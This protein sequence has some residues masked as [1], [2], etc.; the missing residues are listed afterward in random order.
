MSVVSDVSPYL[1]GMPCW[2]VFK[3]DLPRDEVDIGCHDQSGA[4]HEK[5]A[6]FAACGVGQIFQPAARGP[7][8]LTESAQTGA[9]ATSMVGGASVS[10]MY[11]LPLP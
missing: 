11:H 4:P 6:L 9:A 1:L 8:L 5:Q 2:D 7:A 10:R 3:R